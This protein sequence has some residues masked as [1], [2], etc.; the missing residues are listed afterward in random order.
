MLDG[1]FKCLLGCMFRCKSHLKC[2]NCCESD[3]FIEEGEHLKRIDS[4][5]SL[6]SG[7]KSK[8]T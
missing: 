3:C 6:N 8:L 4:K 2:S 7:K 5:T 1:L